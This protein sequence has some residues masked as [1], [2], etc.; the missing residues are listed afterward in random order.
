MSKKLLGILLLMS[1]IISG[2]AAPYEFKSEG[3]ELERSLTLAQKQDSIVQE[4]NET[5]NGGTLEEPIIIVNPFTNA[6]LSAVMEF[7]TEEAVS[8]K[9]I[10]KGKTVA[11]DL[12]YEFPEAQK[13]ILPIIGLMDEG[14]TDVELHIGEATYQYVVTGDDLPE[15][16]YHPVITQENLIKTPNALYFTTP[17]S[18]GHISGYDCN[19]D[20]RFVL[21]SNN[22]WDINMLSDGKLIA[23]SDRILNSPYYTTGFVTMDLLGHIEKEYSL[24]G[25]YHHDIDE[26]PNGNFLVCSDDFNGNTVEDI[27]VEV[28]KE[29]GAIVKR[30]DLKDVLD[31]NDGRSLN[32]T[33]QDWF[34]NNSVDYQLENN[35]LTVSGRHQDIVAVIDYDNGKLRYLVGPNDKWSEEMQPYFLTPINEKEFEWQW[36]Q[37]AATW[38]DSEYLM[39]FDN[40]MNR[41]KL[42]SEALMAEDNYSRMVI[43]KIDEENK[44]IEQVYQYGKERGYQY[45]SPY[46][47]DNDC[48]GENHFLINSGGISYL[49]GKIN[50]DPGSLVA[51]DHMDAFISEIKDGEL[52]FEMQFPCNIYR[53]EKMDVSKFSM[54]ELKDS[55]HLGDLGET[56]HTEVKTSKLV[57]ELCDFNEISAE[58]MPVQISL[59]AD[60]IVAMGT[61]HRE[62]NLELVLV[63]DEKA[64]VY[65][66]QVDEDPGM[67]VAIFNSPKPDESFMIQTVSS[68]GLKGEYRVG[69]IFN[70]TL[71]DST[72]V[73]NY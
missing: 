57:K 52:V 27:I 56:K 40:G 63:Q 14:D 59:E 65:P 37:H 66:F 13:H 70:G 1:L 2:C 9:M 16:I 39:L 71:Y 22:F 6:P 31:Q 15:D 3:Q 10:V 58:E 7:E 32:W 51:H 53:A 20:L 68:K 46:I 24:P 11:A 73:I 48:L 38:L 54:C 18:G 4:L 45:Y 28:D 29:T 35:T 44:T 25:G 17:S 72:F 30:F 43:Y 67:C 34:H 42:T 64:L 19:G 8:V 26:L 47:C 55:I 12:T 21:S 61:L 5:L 23:S 62:D 69:Y 50:N 49:D 41:S 60:R 36:A 33:V